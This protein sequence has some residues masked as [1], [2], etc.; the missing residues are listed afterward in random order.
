MHP[1]FQALLGPWEWRL[2][3][4][5]V[6]VPWAVLYTL[7]WRRLRI[8]V[9]AH[10]LTPRRYLVRRLIAYWAGILIL[11]ISLMSPVDRLGGQLLLM[12]M[13][14][15]KLTMFFAAP[16]ILLGNPFPFVL[17]GMPAR[18]RV[19]VGGLF[20]RNARFR[21]V[22]TAATRPGIAWLVLITVYYGWH[23]PIAYNTALRLDW[24][25]DIQHI[26]FFSASMLFWWHVIGSAPNLHG[27]ILPWMRIGYLLTQIPPNMAVG[28]SIA[29]ST[30]I[31]YT[32][33]ESVPR[34]WGFSVEQDQMLG[35]AIMWIMGSQM[36]IGAALIVLAREFARAKTPIKTSVK[37]SVHERSVTE[38]S[39]GA[40]PTL[41]DMPADGAEDVR[42]GTSAHKLAPG[43][44]Q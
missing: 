17:W 4:L 10:K 42:A 27:R 30:S 15:H 3:V 34:F 7:G 14:Q 22:L 43:S 11:I 18:V 28:I 37:A 16:L 13:V 39:N 20:A 23:D 36:F 31:L 38:L 21:R 12:H 6:I 9:Q 2:E 44:S 40:N 8:Q 26:S 1:L 35:G 19:A 5:A 33:Y 29:F 24:V 41:T 32:Y 25:H